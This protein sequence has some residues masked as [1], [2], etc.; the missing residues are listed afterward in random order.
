MCILTELESYHF[1]EKISHVEYHPENLNYPEH[2]HRSFELWFGE[3]GEFL[4]TIDSETH[5]LKAGDI[6]LILPYQTHQVEA[7]M[8]NSGHIW[9]FSPEYLEDYLPLIKGKTFLNPV[10]PVGRERSQHLY[11][12]LFESKSFFRHKAALYEILYLYE[13]HTKL[14]KTRG[15]ENILELILLWVSSHFE[16][17]ATLAELSE[18]IGYSKDYVSKVIAQKLGATFPKLI[19]Q[20]RIN[21]ACYLLANS[22][23]SITEVSN[24]SGFQNPR[25]FNRNFLQKMERSPKDYRKNARS[26]S[27]DPALIRFDNPYYQQLL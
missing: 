25:T 2:L 1:G 8:E 16:A 19:N 21:H 24:L 17:E 15:K 18:D 4:L 22:D 10:I 12:S 7:T 27:K 9:I 13:Q 26:V 20:Y 11:E 6:A 23:Y 14:V 3:T 5:T